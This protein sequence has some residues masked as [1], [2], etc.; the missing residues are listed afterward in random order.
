MKLLPEVRLDD[1]RS[2]RL[3]EGTVEGST[4]IMGLVFLH[5]DKEGKECEKGTVLW[6]PIGDHGRP[7][8][9]CVADE[10]LTVEPSLH[11]AACGERGY[12]RAGK[13]EAA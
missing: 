8:F 5:H 6:E 9:E 11:C 7:L 4:K 12:I 2:Y 1:Q 13:W 3:L 10:P